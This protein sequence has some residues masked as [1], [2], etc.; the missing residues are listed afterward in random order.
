MSNTAGEKSSH[1][2]RELRHLSYVDFLVSSYLVDMCL[3]LFICK[4]LWRKKK[5]E[6]SEESG[7]TPVKTIWKVSFCICVIFSMSSDSFLL[8]NTDLSCFLSNCFN[9]MQKKKKKKIASFW[10]DRDV[11]S[12]LFS[13]SIELA[14]NGI[15]FYGCNHFMGWSRK[16]FSSLLFFFWRSRHCNQAQAVFLL[17]ST[18]IQ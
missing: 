10:I 2:S 14:T 17:S 8:M 5:F 18:Y 9:P 1:L 11:D 16:R 4:F 3:F 6:V 7:W 12:L 13:Y 15:C